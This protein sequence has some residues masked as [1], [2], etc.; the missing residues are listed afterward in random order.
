MQAFRKYCLQGGFDDIG[1]TLRQ[2][3]KIKAFEATRL[4]TKPWL[5]H[6]ASV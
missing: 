4:A 2:A 5:A 6:T 1:L 3:E